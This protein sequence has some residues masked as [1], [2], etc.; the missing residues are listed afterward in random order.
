MA[1]NS[2]SG[3]D[4]DAKSNAA[5]IILMLVIACSHSIAGENLSRPYVVSLL[6]E[7]EAHSGASVELPD[8]YLG[9]WG[10]G[11]GSDGYVCVAQNET[12]RITIHHEPGGGWWEGFVFSESDRLY[13]YVFAGHINLATGAVIRFSSAS[14]SPRMEYL[15]LDSFLELLKAR[16]LSFRENHIRDRAV[17]TVGYP[18]FRELL[19]D[20]SLSFG[21]KSSVP[22][23]AKLPNEADC[24]VIM[25]QRP[26]N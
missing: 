10:R 6:V 26:S 1:G 17:V 23:L 24:P 19:A 15:D 3:N 13:A 21:G 4:K 16:G 25:F 11:P 7:G 14:G 22:A 2:N 12:N 8:I 9:A 18:V 5:A 20:R